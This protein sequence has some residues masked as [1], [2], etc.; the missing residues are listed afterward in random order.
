[1]SPLHECSL[2]NC[3][4]VDQKKSVQERNESLKL[5]VEHRNIHL[6]GVRLLVSK[7]ETEFFTAVVRLLDENGASLAEKEQFFQGVK[8]N[9]RS[10]STSFY[11]RDVKFNVP[12]LIWKSSK[13]TIEVTIRESIYSKVFPMSK[14]PLAVVK[15]DDFYFTFE[16]NS[17]QIY[18]LLFYTLN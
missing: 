4:E 13:Y 11:G 7:N 17:R 3:I 6:K 9:T 1:M 16:G 2:Y 10:Y 18:Q 15:K 8:L 14:E 5:M 12:V